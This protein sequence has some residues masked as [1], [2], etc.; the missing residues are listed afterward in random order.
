[1]SV[2]ETFIKPILVAIIYNS[3]GNDARNLTFSHKIYQ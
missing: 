3:F 2:N 1:M